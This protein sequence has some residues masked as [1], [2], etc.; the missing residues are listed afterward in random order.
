MPAWPR[1]YDPTAI[2]AGQEYEPGDVVDG[3]RLTADFRWVR[4]KRTKRKEDRPR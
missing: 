3:Y 2:H 1:E 4:V